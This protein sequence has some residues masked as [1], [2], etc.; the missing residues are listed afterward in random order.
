MAKINKDTKKVFQMGITCPH[1]KK[2]MVV[3]K[4][5]KKISEGTAAEYEEKVIVDKATQQ[6]IKESSKKKK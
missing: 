5:K 3:T 2:G 4:T 1:C 6:T